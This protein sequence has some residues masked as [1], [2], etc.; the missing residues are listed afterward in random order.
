[1][2][3]DL[4]EVVT[5][6]A[7]T[8]FTH[9]PA[10]SAQLHRLVRKKRGQES[11]VLDEL[12]NLVHSDPG[13]AF[14]IAR[15]C[16]LNGKPLGTGHSVNIRA[17]LEGAD[18]FEVVDQ[19]SGFDSYAYWFEDY[20]ALLEAYEALVGAARAAA[21]AVLAD[22]TIPAEYR[23]AAAMMAMAEHFAPLALANLVSKEE[24]D[25]PLVTSEEALSV[26]TSKADPD[27]VCREEL[28]F[29]LSEF[30]TALAGQYELPVVSNPIYPGVVREQVRQAVASASAGVRAGGDRGEGTAGA[31]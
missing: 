26:I 9:S 23:D 27:Q 13:F 4:Q 25:Y 29:A 3:R 8:S 14:N 5:K 1:M 18:A 7:S 16:Q 21:A 22:R 2:K 10:T 24:G 12:V 17:R 15:L 6:A 19:L 31:A 28:G 11:Q 20:P 30:G